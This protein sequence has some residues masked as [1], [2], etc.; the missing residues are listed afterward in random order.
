MVKKS[1]T[2]QTKQWNSGES[3]TLYKKL[4]VCLWVGQ[5]D[6]LLERAC[7]LGAPHRT[8][9]WQMGTSFL[10][11]HSYDNTFP[12]LLVFLFFLFLLAQA[13]HNQM[14]QY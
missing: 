13:P 5:K 12:T 14:N 6:Q 11:K 4:N 10:K 7:V 1:S 3:D 2:T 8:R 9:T